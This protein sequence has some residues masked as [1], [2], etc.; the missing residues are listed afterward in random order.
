M[1]ALGKLLLGLPYSNRIKPERAAEAYEDYIKELNENYNYSSTYKKWDV[2]WIQWG[3]NLE[4]E[5]SYKHMGII[6][7]VDN[8]HVYAFPI[9]TLNSN[10]IQITNAYHPILNPNGNKM[11][12]Q[13][14]A[15]DYSFLQHDS[16]IKMTELKMLSKKRILSKCGSIISDVSLKNTITIYVL[17]YF[18][19]EKYNEIIRIRM[20]NSFLRMQLFLSNLKNNYSVNSLDELEDILAIPDNYNFEILTT[21]TVDNELSYHKVKIQLEDEFHQQASK[22]ILCTYVP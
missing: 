1:K 5:M 17:D 6:Y 18:N 11:Y 10:N 13:I 4:P 20:E 8:K 3:N 21:E 2:C 7:K 19:H 9:T 22:E 16:V 14:N 15:Y 12:I